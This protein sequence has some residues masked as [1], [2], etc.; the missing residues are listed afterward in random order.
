[1]YKKA[2]YNKTMLRSRDIVE[3]EPIEWKIERIL[4][5]NEPIVDGAP[6]IYTERAEGILSAYNIRTDRWEIACEGMSLVEKSHQ[7]KRE[8]LAKKR[9]EEKD[10]KVIKMNETGGQSVSGTESGKQGGE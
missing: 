6:E 9:K 4:D 7:A 10:A 1:M 2:V 8:N 5:H 3:G